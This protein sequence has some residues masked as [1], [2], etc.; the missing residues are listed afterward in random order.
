MKEKIYFTNSN[1]I[2]ICGILSN[3]TDDISKPIIILCHGFTTSKD[4][5]TNTRLEILLNEKG[6]STLRFDFFGH[7]ESGGDFAEI[8]VSEGV[9]DTLRAIDYLKSLGYSKIGLMGSSYGGITSLMAAS[10]T[11]DLYVLALKSPV[12]DYKDLYETREALDEWKTKG[13]KA[14]FNSKGVEFKLNYTFFEDF[15]NNLGYEAAKNIHI[16]TLIVHGREDKD[17]AVEQSIK[18]SKILSNGK[19]EIIEDANHF[20]DKSGQFQNMLDL[21]VDFIV[22]IS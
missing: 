19:L 9:D 8:T 14:Y 16:P 2:K 3:P 7:G 13:Y 5:S 10:K 22:K 12:S 17:V 18:T 21:I 6:I 15:D 11:K 20:Y 1:D 4:N